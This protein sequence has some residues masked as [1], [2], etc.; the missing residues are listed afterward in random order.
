MRYY[1][2]VKFV[3]FLGVL[4]VLLMQLL[5]NMIVFNVS[6][7]IMLSRGYVPEMAVAWT[8]LLLISVIMI[9]LFPLMAVITYVMSLKILFVLLQT[10]QII[11]QLV[12]LQ[13][14]Y[15]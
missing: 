6:V 4:I 5:I 1:K 7:A 13:V 11:L 8:L 12:L 2:L 3:L 9:Y 10:Q 14:I 15:H